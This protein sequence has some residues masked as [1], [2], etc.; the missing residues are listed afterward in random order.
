MADIQELIK[1]TNEGN[2]EAQ[3]ELAR[4]YY[5][6]FEPGMSKDDVKKG[7]KKGFDLWKDAA[8]KGYT[9]AYAPLA[10]CY[11]NGSGIEKDYKK[12]VEYFNKSIEA[13]VDN[14]SIILHLG[15]CYFEGLGI[16]VDY[17]KAYK[18]FTQVATD[19][20]M[21]IQGK[22]QL[23]IGKCYYDGK[24]VKQDREEAYKWFVEA[25][26][27]EIAIAE[28]NLGDCYFYGYGVKQDQKE[29]RWLYFRAAEN[30]EYPEAIYKYGYCY[31]GGYG[32]E[33]DLDKAKGLYRLA[34]QKGYKPAIEKLKELGENQ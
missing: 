11:Y 22:A 14:S 34:A 24:G 3:C 32:G 20:D 13:K 33:K 17:D 25:N 26:D 21:Q 27:N 28:S 18:C 7:A 8:E 6:H 5:Y 23:Y 31:E 19:E 15:I 2:L 30:E 16:D 29:A 12:A 1:L 4:E 10:F 9:K